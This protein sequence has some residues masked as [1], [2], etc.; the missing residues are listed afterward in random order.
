[1]NKGS[2]LNNKNEKP[3]II[4]DMDGL[5]FDTE[6]LAIKL[7]DKVGK[8]FGYEIEPELVIKTI[9]IDVKGTEKIFMDHFGGDFP[10]MEIRTLREEYAFRY[11]E[12]K[13]MPV[14]PGLF[15]LLD[16][17][18]DNKIRKALATSSERIK[19]EKYLILGNVVDRFDYAV[20]GDEVKNGKPDPEIFLKVAQKA[21]F[22][23]EECSVLEDSESGILS[24]S[25]AGMKSIFIKDVKDLSEDT[26]KLVFK[27]FKSLL[28]VRDFLKS[29]L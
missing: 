16:F 6:T 5:M 26:K 3:L 20:C 7:W 1:M 29:I 9:G 25:R 27:E 11:M 10:F 23:N 13:G 28:E 24:A 19:A 22:N 2:F 4:F 12:E 14:K 18:E 8:K 17:L 15:E 21:G